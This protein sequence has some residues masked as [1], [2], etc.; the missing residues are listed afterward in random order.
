MSKVITTESLAVKYRPRIIKDLVG[1]HSAQL[2]LTGMVKSKKWP[3]VLLIT[4]GSGTG[5]TTIANIINRYVNCESGNACGECG[6]CMVKGRHPDYL[7]IN[8]GTN[9]GKDDIKNIVSAANNK[10]RFNKR[11]LLLDEAHLFTKQAES[12]FLVPLEN[13]GQNTMYILATTNPEK[14]LPTIIGRCVRLE[15]SAIKEEAIVKRLLRIAK[16]EGHD[17]KNDDGIE[18]L[19]LAASLSGGS[20]RD[21]IQMLESLIFAIGSGEEISPKML[22]QKYITSIQVDVEKASASLL[23]ALLKQDLKK[24]LTHAVKA[25]SSRLLLSKVRWLINQ[26]LLDYT[27][28]STYATVNA[29][30]FYSFQEKDPVKISYSNLLI[31][32]ACLTQAEVTMNSAPIDENIIFLSALGD[33]IERITR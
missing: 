8:I 6:S 32:Q 33:Y 19:T 23:H 28:K 12:A 31:L 14:V 10:P 27:K 20:M 30:Y 17:L 29:K 2:Q 25:D 16:L 3:S 15:L 18:A 5:K 22:M 1:Q 21:A 7:E 11:I 13:P 24:V 26:L 9:G 4:G